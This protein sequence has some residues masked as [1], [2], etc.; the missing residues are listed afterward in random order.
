M[1]T[2]MRC[3]K[4][5]LAAGLAALLLG[6]AALANSTGTISL[7]YLTDDLYRDVSVGGSN[8]PQFYNGIVGRS[9]FTVLGPATGEGQNIWDYAHTWNEGHVYTYCVDLFTYISPG[10][11][12]LFNVAHLED[13]P[14]TSPMSPA[15]ADDLRRLFAGHVPVGGDANDDTAAAFAAAVWEIVYEEGAGYD[16]R[17]GTIT[18][19]ERPHSTPEPSWVGMANDYLGNLSEHTAIGSVRA[20]TSEST[21]DF[22]LIIYAAGDMP[23]PIPEPLTMASAFLAIGGLGLY[24]RKRTRTSVG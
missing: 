10:N 23:P 12:Y 19:T 21:Q 11:D 6:S 8:P 18:V 7:H 2:A 13:A 15:K 1:E 14:T 22:A 5:T 17:S 24:I 3:G 16:V 4:W 20:L 9:D